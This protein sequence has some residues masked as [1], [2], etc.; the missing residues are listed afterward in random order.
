MVKYSIGIDVSMEKFH[1]CLSSID[2]S[3]KVKVERSGT[4]YNSEKGFSAF[5]TWI[6][7]SLKNAGLSLTITMEATGVYYEN[8]ALFLY[9]KGYRVSVVLPNKAKKYMEALNLKSKNDKIDAKGL[10]RMGAEQSLDAWL[11]M[12]E[13]FYQL[14]LLT[15]HYQSLQEMCT[16]VTNQQH[17]NSFGMYQ[18]K[19]VNNAHKK[20]IKLVKAQL[21]EANKAIADHL[22]SHPEVSERVAGIEKIK[23]VSMLTIAVLLAETNGFELFSSASQLVSYAG[24]DVVENQSGKH[25]GKTK[26]S[27]KG[28]GR[29]RRCLHMPALNVVRFD[30]RVFKQ[31]FDRTL[32]KHGIKMKS[33][34]AVQKKILTTIYA[35]WKKKAHFDANYLLPQETDTE[36]HAEINTQA[37]SEIEETHQE[38]NNQPSYGAEAEAKKSSP[39]ENRATQGIQ[40][41]T[42]RRLHPLGYDKGNNESEKEAVLI[43]D[44]QP[45]VDLSV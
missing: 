37:K 21:L 11:P 33:Y 15:R 25:V 6:R 10:S 13:Y 8:L 3:Q 30:V 4:F 27:K 43:S 40:P 32:D 7:E 17:A 18:Q 14:R 36:H 16:I 22:A 23:G 24:Y 12:G 29:I 41:S 5:K 20:M 44:G 2:A 35:L 31:L 26:I 19:T 45:K 9:Q 42:D 39:I 34:V 28:N 38:A 1:A